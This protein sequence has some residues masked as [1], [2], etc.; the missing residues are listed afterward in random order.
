MSARTKVLVLDDEEIVC[1]RL[2]AHLEKEDCEVETFTSSQEAIDRLAAKRFDVVVTDL[3]M[4]GPSGL[5][6]LHFLR[7]HSPATQVIMITGYA[8]IE[9]AREAEWGGVFEFVTKPFELDAMASLVA[10]A[11]RKAGRSRD[12]GEGER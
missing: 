11:A 3:K 7:G 10:K 8:T 2:K 4:P 9:A 1:E 6:V 5:D 12:R